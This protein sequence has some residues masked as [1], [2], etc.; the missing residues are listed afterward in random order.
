M[1]EKRKVPIENIFYMLSY[2]WGRTDLINDNYFDNNDDFESSEILAAIFLKNMVS[3]LNVGLYR[4]YLTINEEL[5]G[6]KGKV[7]FKNSI[8]N[9]SFENAK[10]F[11]EYDDFQENNLINKIIKSTAHKLYK[12]DNLKQETKS[13]VNDILLRFNNVDIIDIQDNTLDIKFNRNNYYSYQ[14]IKICELINTMTIISEE[15]GK[16]NFFDYFDDDEQMAKLFELFIFRFYKSKEKE[17]DKKVSFQSQISWNVDGIEKNWLP[18]MELD[19]LLEGKEEVIIIDTKYYKNFYNID[20]RYNQENGKKLISSNLY[21]IF[22]YI[23][24]FETDKKLQGILLYP[25]SYT[26]E[27]ANINYQLKRISK[28]KIEPSEMKIKT[29]DLNQNWITIEEELINLLN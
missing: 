1:V 12:L 3:Y 5:K 26:S 20:I 24:N 22:A 23:N 27:D 18:R 21:Q 15:Y 7:D 11:C 13:K 2:V 9:L 8:N 10:A 6:I 19:I 14:I 4:E 16:Y 17:I 29:I 28:D 25:R